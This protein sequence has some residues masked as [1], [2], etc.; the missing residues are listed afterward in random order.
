MQNWITI[1]AILITG[2]ITL[3]GVFLGAWLTWRCLR[4]DPLIEKVEVNETTN[5]A[6]EN[7]EN[8]TDDIEEDFNNVR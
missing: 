2:T 5:D 4:P 6:S 8:E 1:I 3:S 7:E